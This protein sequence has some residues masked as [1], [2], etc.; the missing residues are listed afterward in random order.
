MPLQ[1]IVS[2]FIYYPEPEWMVTPDRLGLTAQDV[3]LTPEPGV[4]LHGWFFSFPQPFE[5]SRTQPL[6]TL[7]FCHGNAGNISHR[8]ENAYYL[9]RTGFQVLLFDYRG[10]GHSSGEPSEAGLYRDAEAMWSHLVERED[11]VGVP[12][13][14]FGRSLGGAVAV[15]LATCV[16]ADGLIVESTFTSI[17][18]LARLMF[19][20]PLPDLP[21]KYDSLSKIGKLKMPLLAIHGERD[22]LIPFDDGRVLFDAAP[23]PKAWYPISGA[24]HND[25]YLAGGQAYFQRLAAFVE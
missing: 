23:E 20:M 19:P 8:L 17:R 7:L 13:V 5:D 25:T 6:A 11:T 3:Y 9:L 22:E 4:R 2:K 10:Y 12:R 21:V 15:E 18:T 1:H 16:Q 14:I 24:G